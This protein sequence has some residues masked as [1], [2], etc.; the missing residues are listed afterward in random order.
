[1]SDSWTVSSLLTVATDQVAYG[2][3]CRHQSYVLG[4]HLCVCLMLELTIFCIT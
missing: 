1:M 4:R 3:F 2:E